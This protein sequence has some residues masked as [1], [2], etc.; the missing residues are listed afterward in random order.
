MTTPDVL[1]VGAGVIGAACA[2]ELAGAGLRVSVLE[3]AAPGAEASGASAG[4]LSGFSDSRGD[5][6]ARL[7]QLGRDLYDPLADAL[8]EE[9]D[10][11]IELGRTGHLD[12]CLTEADLE[13]ARRVASAPAHRAERLTVL[14][15]EELRGLELG[16]TPE[17]CGALHIPRG[18][19]VDTGKL[20][21]ALVAA[22]ERRG[23]RYHLGEA[24]EELLRERGRVVGVRVAGRRLAAGAVLVA[25][26][27]WSG[28]LAGAPRELRVRP[29]KGQMLAL[30]NAPGTI[31][32]VLYRG[33]AYLVP[34][35]SGECL[36]G[37]T[38]EDGVADRRVT[39]EGLDRLTAQAIATAPGLADAPFLRAWAGIRP[40][41]P[42]GLPLVGPWP[43]D[44]GLHVATGHY[45]NGIL[46]APVTARI[47]REW[48]TEGASS[49]G[50]LFRPGRLAAAP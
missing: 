40:A 48:L 15:A 12:L 2:R 19:W 37:A 43:G 26:G 11:D 33:E 28:A 1:V 13:W 24:V 9:T 14:T 23:A 38:V 3:R 25:A 35:L 18:S 44:P 21:R 27:A 45:R 46:L 47:A 42:D 34:R 20:V 30:G 29:V 32:H 31:R 39:L 10:I 5:R 6:L 4:I 7:C 22:G 41:S 8:R 16:V 49:L 17:A 36:V 50:E